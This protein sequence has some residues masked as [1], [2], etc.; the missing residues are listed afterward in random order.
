MSAIP[1]TRLDGTPD[2]P[3]SG[4]GLD[5]DDDDIDLDLAS[6][7]RSASHAAA[8][9]TRRSGWVLLALVIGV[10]A[11]LV[12]LLVGQI[13][14]LRRLGVAALRGA[15]AASAAAA[16]TAASKQTQCVC[17]GPQIVHVRNC[18]ACCVLPAAAA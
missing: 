1:M 7:G 18:T 15:L 16:I 12:S 13:A 2:E 9:S 4:G 17:A 6:L 14:T 3:G 5:D 10:A 8:S 11:A